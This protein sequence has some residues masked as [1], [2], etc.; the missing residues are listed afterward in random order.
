[1]L[2][3]FFALNRTI[4][5][6]RSVISSLASTRPIDMQ[7]HR[8]SSAFTERICFWLNIVLG[9]LCTWA[10]KNSINSDG[11]SYLDLGDAYLRADW[12]KPPMAFLSATRKEDI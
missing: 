5:P 8:S 9:V 10:G 4:A 6:T 3:F 12:A 2:W 1:M 7:P 11:I